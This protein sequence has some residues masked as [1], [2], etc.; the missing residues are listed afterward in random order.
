MTPTHTELADK[1]L[2]CPFCGCAPWFGRERPQRDSMIR[3]E[4]DDCPAHPE[5]TL[6]TDR[7]TIQGWNTRT[8]LPGEAGREA[9]A[10]IIDPGAFVQPKHPTI[11]DPFWRSQ[12]RQSAIEKADAILALRTPSVNGGALADAITEYARDL[13]RNSS[14][15]DCPTL[16]LEW[17]A[18]VADYLDILVKRHP[19]QREDGEFYLVPRE[20]IDQFPEININ[21]YDHDDTCALNAWGCDV[22][23]NAKL[24]ALDLPQSKDARTAIPGEA[25][26]EEELKKHI[27]QLQAKLT[28]CCGSYVAD[29]H[30]MSDGHSPVSMYDYAL[31][32]ANERIKELEARSPSVNGAGAMREALR[33]FAE[34]A[35][36]NRSAVSSE[37]MDELI[38]LARKACD[39]YT[40]LNIIAAALW[41]LEALAD[42]PAGA[43]SQGQEPS[44][45]KCIMS[46]DEIASA[47]GL[48]RADAP[49]G[50][51]READLA[52]QELCSRYGFATGHGDTLSTMIKEIDHQI[53]ERLIS[54]SNAP[55][56]FELCVGC[57]T[58]A[59]CNAVNRCFAL[60]ARER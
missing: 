49:A 1:L 44:T 19:A 10:Q 12:R 43:L 46:P 39:D 50:A 55:K 45:G 9:I 18:S 32:Q 26:R 16:Q 11:D 14:G 2:P 13:H 57:Y 48:I 58:K 7:L 59:E 17:M 41:A 60:S 5:V 24:T 6:V 23:T 37:P 38:R 34:W 30:P 28:C 15:G 54:L 56:P 21:N 51:L 4:N 40:R 42:A 22:V 29:H 20:I 33:P 31:D 27:E 36:R 25:G 47:K 53:G 3:C 52:C 8:P 35:D